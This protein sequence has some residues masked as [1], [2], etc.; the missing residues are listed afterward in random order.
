MVKKTDFNAKVAE[1]E[2][3]IPSI[4]G[5][6]TNSA[7]TAVENK[8]PDVSSLVK[9]ADY[10]TKISEIENKVNDHN[11][12]KYITTPEFNTL[13]ADVFKVRLAAQTDLIRKP[14]F[15]FKLKEISDRVT[16]NK[17]TQ[18]LV[19]NKLKKLQKFGAAY[20]RG[21]NNFEVDGK[22]NYLVFQ[23]M[24]RHS[25]GIAG[26]GSGNY[27]YFWKSKG[28][29]NERIDS[30]T[31]SNHKITTELSFYGTKRR[32]EFNGGC[33]KQDKVTYNHGKIVKIYIV[34]EISQNH[35]ISS[36]P[37]SENCL[38]GAVSLTKN[39]NIDKYKYS[40]YGIGFDRHGD[41]S[42][43][44]GLGKKCIIFG[45]DLISSSRANKKIIIIL[46]LVKILY[47]E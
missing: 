11:H 27:I 44:Y 4:S 18:L 8:I 24:Y 6:A 9:K 19:E 36:Y 2:G 22:Q 29:S 5:L 41:F 32:V 37:T 16:K 45:A 1:I 15:D 38:F 26:V 23:P 14:E 7:L 28:F 21:K 17:T 46:F 40:G 31:A 13:A 10:N 33:L 47:K 35:S 25:K 43:G 20:F 39:A 34:Y 12:D 3:K 30:I 42:F